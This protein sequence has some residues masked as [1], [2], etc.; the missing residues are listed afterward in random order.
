MD[1]QEQILQELKA[2][3]QLL[4]GNQNQTAA[5]HPKELMQEILSTFPPEIRKYFEMNKGE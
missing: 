2:I 4:E 5:K 1:I 3:R